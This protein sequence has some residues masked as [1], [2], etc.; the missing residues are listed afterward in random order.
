MTMAK[1]KTIPLSSAERGEQVSAFVDALTDTSEAGQEALK[2]L[3]SLATACD[4]S[5]AIAK[6]RELAEGDPDLAEWLED[7]GWQ[8]PEEEDY[9]PEDWPEDE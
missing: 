2:G 7:A 3:R 6:L 1:W 8:A 4:L 9:A 5:L